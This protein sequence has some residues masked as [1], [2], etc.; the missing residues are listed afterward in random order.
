MTT[1]IITKVYTFV[2]E[3]IVYFAY[4]LEEAVSLRDRLEN[5]FPVEG[6]HEWLIAEVFDESSWFVKLLFRL[7]RKVNQ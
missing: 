1:Y 4:S 7:A 2:P 6:R 3:N 5:E